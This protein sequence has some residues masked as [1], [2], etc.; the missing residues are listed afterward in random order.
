MSTLQR[1]GLAEVLERAEF[2]KG[3]GLG[4]DRGWQSHSQ[5]GF[6]PG[7]GLTLLNTRGSSFDHLFWFGLGVFTVLGMSTILHACLCKCYPTD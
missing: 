1:A 3:N 5:A 7:L 4:S 6:S 2:H